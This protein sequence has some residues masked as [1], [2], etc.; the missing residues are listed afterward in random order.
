MNFVALSGRLTRDPEIRKTQTGIDVCSFTVAVDRPG[1][2][3]DNKVTDFFNCTAWGSQNG[4]GIAGVIGQYF[5]KGDGIIISEGQLQTQ[6]WQ[7]KEG[8]SRTDTKII[9][10]QFEFPMGRRSG[11]PSA[12]PAEPAPQPTQVDM[13]GELPF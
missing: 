13:S 1:T 3:K 2:K 10:R 8:N 6:K 4:P 12:Q 7:D 11:E 9:V 5:H